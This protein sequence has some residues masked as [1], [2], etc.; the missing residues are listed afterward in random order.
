MPTPSATLPFCGSTLPAR[1]RRRG[2]D[3]PLNC[4]REIWCSRWVCFVLRTARLGRRGFTHRRPVPRTPHLVAA[5]QIDA[6]HLARP[7]LLLI[8]TQ[9]PHLILTACVC[10]CAHPAVCVVRSLLC[11]LTSHPV[12][13]SPAGAPAGLTNSISLGIV[14]SI[15]RTRSELGMRGSSDGRDT[16]VYI[17]TDAAINQVGVGVGEGLSFS[18]KGLGWHRRLMCNLVG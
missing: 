8:H 16:T 14:S 3:R 17:Q 9:V 10:V 15:Q 11:V 12:T 1:C 7:V 5:A 18:G 2:S 13:A 4:G 6:S